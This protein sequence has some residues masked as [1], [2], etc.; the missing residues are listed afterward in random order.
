[1]YVCMYVT[2][3]LYKRFNRTILQTSNSNDHLGEQEVSGELKPTEKVEE[4][5][6]ISISKTATGSIANT[7]NHTTDV[8]LT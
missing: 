6:N 2:K 4:D 8:R 3:Y 5:F 7:V 1:M